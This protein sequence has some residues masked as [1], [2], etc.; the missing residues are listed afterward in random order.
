MA[1]ERGTV[2]SVSLETDVKKQAGGTYKA[3][4]LVYKTPEGEIRNIAKPVTGLRFNAALKESLASLQPDDEFTLT[5][6]KNAAGFNDVKTIV[7]GFV[8]DA[9]APEAKSSTQAGTNQTTARAGGAS[10]S[11]TQRDYETKEERLAKQNAIVRQSSLSNAIAV[12][13]TGAKA[14]PSKEDIFALA[15]E[16]VDF[17]GYDAPP[18][19]VAKGGAFDD[20]QD[21]I[22]Y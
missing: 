5:Q 8:T 15:Q 20:F 10:N 19:E 2:I 22:P 7:K 9:L 17:V 11:Y 12:L 1:T 16:F 6:E 18:K 21:D 3:W 13:T 4:Q 14:P